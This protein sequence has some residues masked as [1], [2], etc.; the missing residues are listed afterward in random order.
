[1]DWGKPTGGILESYKKPRIT[2]IPATYRGQRVVQSTFRVPASAR[3]APEDTVMVRNVRQRGASKAKMRRR[4]Y[5]KRRSVRRRRIPSTLTTPTKLVRMVITF[6]TTLT[7]T[8]AGIQ[9]ADI[10]LFNVTDPLGALSTQQPTSLDQWG[11]LYGKLVVVGM[12][13]TCTYHNAGTVGV[14]CGITPVPDEYSGSLSGN[15]WDYIT[16]MPGTKYRFLSPEMD[17]TTM[18]AKYS[19]K[20]WMK[21]KDWK[22]NKDTIAR[23][24]DLGSTG[25]HTWTGSGLTNDH[26]AVW[27]ALHSGTTSTAVNVIVKCEYIC[28]LWDRRL[29]P[30][31]TA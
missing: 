13:L 14:V 4:R 24:V 7:A 3:S 19:A 30:R 15:T 21:I 29:I 8:N 6:P 31:S 22:D 1:M 23:R 10:S 11:A 17:H 18:T 25:T 16:E 28:M 26:V 12:R 2:G 5:R 27:A 20:R 9:T